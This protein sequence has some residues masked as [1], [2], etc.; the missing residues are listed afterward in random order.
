MKSTLQVNP[1][2]RIRM[3]IT[4]CR[5]NCRK[6]EEVLIRLNEDW[7]P[8][9]RILVNLADYIDLNVTD[10]NAANEM[11]VNAIE[12]GVKQYENHVTTNVI[13]RH[14]ERLSYADHDRLAA[15]L[16]GVISDLDYGLNYNTKSNN[17][18]CRDIET[19]EKIYNTI[20]D[21][22]LKEY[23]RRNNHEDAILRS[24]HGFYS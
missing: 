5:L 23:I 10:Q 6:R 17:L 13:K 9:Y 12:S 15:F 22:R 2:K 1:D 20:V 19:R 21:N 8:V 7:P 16:Y 3:A 14:E 4:K 11:L 24:G 18:E